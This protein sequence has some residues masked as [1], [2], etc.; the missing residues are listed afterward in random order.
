MAQV[1][2]I[3]VVKQ[4]SLGAKCFGCKIIWLG[5][6]V[7]H[8]QSK[9][10]WMQSTKKLCNNNVILPPADAQEYPNN[11]KLGAYNV[12]LTLKGP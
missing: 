10:V 4:N 2:D 11:I 3:S 1:Q 6:E 12:N 8:M 9:I 5:C 7:F